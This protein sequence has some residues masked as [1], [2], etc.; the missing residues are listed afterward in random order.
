MEAAVERLV[1]WFTTRDKL[2][3]VLCL[4]KMPDPMAKLTDRAQHALAPVLIGSL[5]ILAAAADFAF[6]H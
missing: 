1:T 4:E 6:G 5:P 3:G 2:N